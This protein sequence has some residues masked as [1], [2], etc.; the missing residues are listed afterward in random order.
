MSEEI[1]KLL[2]YISD[3]NSKKSQKESQDAKKKSGIASINPRYC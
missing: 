2:N 3:P 1:R